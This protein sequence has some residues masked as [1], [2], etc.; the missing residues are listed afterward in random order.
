[1]ARIECPECGEECISETVN[2]CPVCGYSFEKEKEVYHFS[3]SACKR[4]EPYRKVE[5]YF[6]DCI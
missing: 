5:N 4:F 6:N 3:C 1:M 2:A